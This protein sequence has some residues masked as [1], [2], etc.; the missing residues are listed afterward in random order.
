LHEWEA[1]DI[2][3]PLDILVTELIGAAARFKFEKVYGAMEKFQGE[4]FS[5][6][7]KFFQDYVYNKGASLRLEHPPLADNLGLS[8]DTINTWKR[9]GPLEI[10]ESSIVK[11]QMGMAQTTDLNQLPKEFNAVNALRLGV[12]GFNAFPPPN[13]RDRNWRDRVPKGGTGR[14]STQGN[15]RGGYGR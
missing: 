8:V 14:F 2:Q 3:T 5:E 9:K 15:I 11:T 1:L 6:H 4:D 13:S 10:P 12:C 7:T